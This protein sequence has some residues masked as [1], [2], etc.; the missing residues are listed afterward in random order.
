[1]RKRTLQYL[2]KLVDTIDGVDGGLYEELE[3]T[4]EV[5]LA[6][7]IAHAEAERLRLRASLIR[8]RT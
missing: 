3:N 2:A 8:P 6:R 4:E 1:V 5:E 7:S